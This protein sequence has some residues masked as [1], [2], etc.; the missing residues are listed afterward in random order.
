MSRTA[1]KSFIVTAGEP[2]PASVR[3]RITRTLKTA[4]IHCVTMGNYW[5]V[6]SGLSAREI[7][8]TLNANALQAISFLIV[9]L[10]HEAA[11]VNTSEPNARWLKTHL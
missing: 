8:D 3:K 1:N 10:N 7:R 2:L 5:I 4:S 6:K 9:R 11:W